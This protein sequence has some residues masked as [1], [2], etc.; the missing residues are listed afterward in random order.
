VPNS[1]DQC[2]CKPCG[3]V[4]CPL[5]I[6]SHASC[7]GTVQQYYSDKVEPQNGIFKAFR[8]CVILQKPVVFYIQQ[9]WS[10][11]HLIRMSDDVPSQI[12]CWVWWL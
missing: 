8:A 10:V 11:E 4:C 5:C 2:S 9:K 7:T 1:S 12:H 6:H 3:A